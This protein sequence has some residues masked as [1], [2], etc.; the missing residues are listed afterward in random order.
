MLRLPTRKDVDTPQFQAVHELTTL[1]AGWHIGDMNFARKAMPSMTA[2]RAAADLLNV[3]AINMT[4]DVA[5]LALSRF[6]YTRALIAVRSVDILRQLKDRNFLQAING[7]LFLLPSF[8]REWRP[9]YFV[10]QAAYIQI[11]AIV[12]VREWKEDKCTSISR[13]FLTMLNAYKLTSYFQGKT[14]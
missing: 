11:Q 8:F 10:T 5:Y 1:L 6:G 3:N 13:A 14:I 2:C 4:F 9:V 12:A 7:T